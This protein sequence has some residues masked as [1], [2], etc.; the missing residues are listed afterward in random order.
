MARRRNKVDFDELVPEDVIKSTDHKTVGELNSIIQEL[1]KQLETTVEDY[2]KRIEDLTNRIDL[3]EEDFKEVLNAIQKAKGGAV[4]TPT[5]TPAGT[6][7][8]PSGPGGPSGGP[9]G[10]PTGSPAIPKL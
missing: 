7:T 5:A 3:L 8:V 1:E 4:A 9:S 6:A 10:G 2:E